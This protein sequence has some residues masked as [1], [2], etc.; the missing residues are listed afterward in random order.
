[1]GW[2]SL[3]QRSSALLLLLALLWSAN[4]LFPLKLPGDELARVVLT[5]EDRRFY[6]HPGVNPLAL[7]RAAWRNLSGGRMFSVTEL[8]RCRSG[9]CSIRTRETP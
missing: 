8:C 6:R 4:R 1:M 7:L 2:L 5:Y 3:Y 9:G